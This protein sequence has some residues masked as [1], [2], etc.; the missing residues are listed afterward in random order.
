MPLQ[1][2]IL[3]KVS[4]DLKTSASA[5]RASA[6]CWAKSKLAL[7]LRLETLV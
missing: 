2:S 4:T 5:K 1:I 3:V 7:P 6:S